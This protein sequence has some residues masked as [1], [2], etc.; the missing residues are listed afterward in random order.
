MV[1]VLY[2]LLYRNDLH[3]LLGP[4][5]LHAW[6]AEPA[7]RLP[8]KDP[9]FESTVLDRLGGAVIVVVAVGTVAFLSDAY[10]RLFGDA[11]TN[12]VAVSAS[13]A[14]AWLNLVRALLTTF[15]QMRQGGAAV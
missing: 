4:P 3:E 7:Q 8:Q 13:A 11:K 6:G 1:E 9:G 5:T 14:F 10:V 15:E 2:E 12:V